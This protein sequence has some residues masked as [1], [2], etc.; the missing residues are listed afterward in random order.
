MIL[1]ARLFFRF[2]VAGFFASVAM[3]FFHLAAAPPQTFGQ[4]VTTGTTQLPPA[5]Q[6]ALSALLAN[7]SGTLPALPTT[8]TLMQGGVLQT[9]GATPLTTPLAT[10]APASQGTAT[11]KSREPD[12]PGF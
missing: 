11:P 4:G 12:D 2:P 6:A 10:P 9:T 8:G 1:K 5:A 3:L 7:T